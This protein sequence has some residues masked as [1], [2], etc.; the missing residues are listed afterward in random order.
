MFR[1]SIGTDENVPGRR[2]CFRPHKLYK[3]VIRVTSRVDLAMSVHPSVRMNAEISDTI[4]ARLLGLGIQIPEF[5]AQVC[6]IRAP[7]PL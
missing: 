5:F 2:K 6:F 7:R 4:R 3:F 1:Q